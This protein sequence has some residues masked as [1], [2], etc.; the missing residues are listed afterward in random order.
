MFPRRWITP[1]ECA[2]YLSLNV[3]TVYQKFYRHEIPGARIG[4]TV[5]IDLKA[6]EAMLEAKE[7][8]KPWT[9]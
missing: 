6:L 7:R 2:E 3:Q 1:K 8:N 9:S 4:R 5:R